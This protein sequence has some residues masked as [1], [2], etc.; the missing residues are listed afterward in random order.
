MNRLLQHIIL[1]ITILLPHTLMMAQGKVI[2][3]EIMQ[4]NV[5]FLKADHDF[6]DSWVELHNIG[7]ERVSVKG[8]RIG[9]SRAFAETFPISK[10]DDYYIEPGGYLTIYCDKTNSLPLHCNFNL[11]TDGGKL[12]LVN[13]NWQIID[14]V[15]Y[16]SMPA[17]NVAYGRITDGASEWQYEMTATPGAANNSTECHEI[18]PAPLFSAE[19]HLMTAASETIT[20]SMPWG[21]PDDTRI[22]LTTDGSEPDWDSVS[23]TL[24]TLTIDTNT[25]VRAKLLS[26]KMLPALSTSH[27]YIYPPRD[28]K[29]PIVS[30]I[31]DSTYLYS[32]E[33]GILSPDSTDGKPNYRYDWRRP[34]NFEYFCTENGSTVFSQFGEM[35]VFG[36]NS[37]NF[38]Q[39]S[40]KCYAKKRFGK[41]SFKG[42]FWQDKPNVRK[43]KSFTL[44]NGGG[45]CKYGRFDDA[46]VHRLF[47]THLDNMD[48]QAYEPVLV[49]INGQYKGVFGMRE[50]SNEDY[51]TSNYGIDEDEVEMATNGNYLRETSSTPLFN[52][53]RQLYHR[54]NVTYTEMAQN[55]NVENFM[56]AFIAEC[57]AS[58]TDF[59][60]NNGSMWRKTTEDGRWHWIPKDMD[61]I[62][63]NTSSWNMFKYMLG[64]SDPDDQEYENANNPS[65]RTACKLYEK[66][67]S[68][69]EFRNRFLATY[70]T[71]LGDFLRPDVCVPLISEMEEEIITELPYTFATY[72]GMTT[73]EKHKYGLNRL[74]KYVSTRP[75]SVYQH[76]ADYFSL[77]EVIPVSITAD[78]L[79]EEEH[80][81]VTVSVCDTPLR[82]GRFDGAWFTS[83]PMNLC[84]EAE[85]GAWLMTIT[86]ENGSVSTEVFYTQEF[87][88]DLTSCVPGDSVAIV[89]TTAEGADHIAPSSRN[90]RTTT[91]I[92]DATGKK[93]NRM[94]KGF[95]IILYSNGTRKKVLYK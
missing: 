90:S 69:P 91:A 42:D 80:S 27:S 36:A 66:M 13:N 56:N 25:V 16:K 84:T 4:S 92:Y 47:G 5:N 64:T 72:V 6:P 62:F 74:Y 54:D 59:P 88:P 46:F 83:F 79:Q 75:D 58:N 68:F 57:Y 60:H 89:A 67:M 37:R 81:H 94:Q 78:S 26:Q 77:G 93:L 19:G 8:Y 12:Y 41:N 15:T 76:M 1:W 33:D 39:K 30:I 11:E 43:V 24:F 18:L 53:F 32:S 3:N 87:Q 45:S 34:G 38:Q 29:L 31:T 28:T 2:I 73:L 21:V 35:A 50:R 86:H 9:P 40:L 22:Y 23:D 82:T 10:T 71:Y 14:S 44:R 7:N 20:V 51:V 65:V 52:E 61:F 70:A 85:N 55:M 48:W 95:N 49:Y 63:V 17:P